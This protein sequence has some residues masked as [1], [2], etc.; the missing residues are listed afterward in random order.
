MDAP[1]ADWRSR[2]TG[3]VDD[4]R[5]VSSL[6]AADEGGMMRYIPNTDADR[7]VMLAAMGLPAVEDLF[8]GIPDSLRIAGPLN[9]PRALAEQEMLR[10]MRALAGR[11]ADVEDYTAFL[12]AG[13][14]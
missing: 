3:D 9:I 1:G 6:P 12:G 11:N 13:A 14:Y 2:P 10:Q 4:G 8:S 7:Q 5:A